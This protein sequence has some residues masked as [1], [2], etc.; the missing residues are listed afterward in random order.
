MPFSAPTPVQKHSPQ[1]WKTTSCA[2]LLRPCALSTN[3][4][5]EA[6]GALRPLPVPRCPLL[7][8]WG[9]RRRARTCLAEETRVL[10]AW[11]PAA[12]QGPPEQ[13]PPRAGPRGAAR[14]RKPP[15]PASA[16]HEVKGDDGP[17]FQELRE[18]ETSTPGG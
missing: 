4:S 8:P 6:T 1:S 14:L 12:P 5:G 10:T 7:S 17:R 15:A 18:T 13:P 11:S 3:N 16:V 2:L 9:S